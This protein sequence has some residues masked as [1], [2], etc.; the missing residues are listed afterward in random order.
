MI[1]FAMT[2][3]LYEALGVTKDASAD[4]IRKA[5]RKA[6]ITHHPDKGGDPEK[7]KEIS[8][9]YQVLSDEEK[10]RRYDDLGDE[11]YSASGG[12][13]MSDFGMNPHDLFEQLFRGGGGGFPFHFDFGFG[14]GG[15][16]RGPSKRKD[17]NHTI[18]ISL[19]DAYHGT[20]KVLRVGLKKPCTKCRNQCYTCQGRG[21][22]TDMRR[23]GF[24]TQMMTRA[25]DACNGSGAVA[26]GCNECQQR[27]H[28]MDEK[29][30]DVKVPPGVQTG[31]RFVISGMGEQALSDNEIAGDLVIEI[32]VQPDPNFQRQ[33]QD[34]VFT[35]KLTLAE[36]IV[37]K[38]IT[39]PHFGGDIVISLEDYGIV[40]PHKSYVIPNK[41]MPT[42]GNLILLFQIDYTKKQ[43]LTETDR[44]MLR[45]AFITCGMLDQV[46]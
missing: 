16:H 14:D 27:G 5:Y 8:N 25:C 13:G 38:M 29:K 20:Q 28:V 45:T 10:R 34:L 21:T 3:K 35:A 33:G 39:I 26:K 23:M 15:H 18:N 32:F 46:Q 12:S 9:A 4:D 40:Q 36:S 22:I 37:G 30:I 31:H 44:S 42:N 43:Q 19:A 41:G 1:F 17:H 7:F 6:A 11:G 24:M 2:H